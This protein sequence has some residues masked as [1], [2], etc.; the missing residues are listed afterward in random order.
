MPRAGSRGRDQ[1][2]QSTPEYVAI[3]LTVVAALL[4]I[5]LL[6]VGGIAR[7]AAGA[8]RAAMCSILP[9]ECPGGEGTAATENP[10]LPT[11]PCITASSSRSVAANI[12]AF[13]VGVEG[14]VE[15][16][17]EVRS[18]GT[19]AVTLRGTGAVGGKIAEG[20]KAR[21]ETGDVVTG[22]GGYAEASLMGEFSGARTYVFP[23]QE[24]ANEFIS[25]IKSWA[26]ENATSFA[27]R[28]A[29]G[30]GGLLADFVYRNV[31]ADHVD[32]DFP[33]AEET[34]FKGGIRLEGQAGVTSPTSYAEVEGA[35]SAS[36]GGKVNHRTGDVTV[37]YEVDLAADGRAGLNVFGGA[38]LGGTGNAVVALTFDRDGHPKSLSLT[39]TAQGRGE[40]PDFVATWKSLE[41]VSDGLRSVGLD[42]ENQG[43]RTW[44][45]QGTL[46]LADDPEAQATALSW[47][48]D[49]LKGPAHPDFVRSSIALA[50][51]LDRAGIITLKE[52][53]GDVSGIQGELAAAKGLTFEI[54]GGY[55]HETAHLVEARYREPGLGFVD[56]PNCVG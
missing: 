2:G 19:V 47:L 17:R 12:T 27:L 5:A 48:A 16:R 53:E 56:I 3:I 10:F 28:H 45:L 50:Q 42:V 39:G 43:T 15:G 52:Y 36:L 51:L 46:D 55:S 7:S 14:E 44:E 26:I 11:E 25:D 18:D 37:F 22:G 35:L 8:V 29:P 13:S 33:D 30:G 1:R 40:L 4:A 23:D 21:L 24:A 6:D 9:G 38:S 34:Y 32:M 20:G 31:I 41:D 49:H 54:G